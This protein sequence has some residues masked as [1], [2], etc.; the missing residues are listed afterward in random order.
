[1]LQFQSARRTWWYFLDSPSRHRRVAWNIIYKCP[2][3][4]SSKHLWK[5]FFKF[6]FSS[7]FRTIAPKVRNRRSVACNTF[8]F[9]FINWGPMSGVFIFGLPLHKKK[10][11]PAPHFIRHNSFGGNTVTE[12]EEKGR[13][14]WNLTLFVDAETFCR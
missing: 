4:L 12:E 8:N 14:K 3:E 9:L 6:F 7:Q 13:E 11:F 1:M 5:L 2:L 10:V